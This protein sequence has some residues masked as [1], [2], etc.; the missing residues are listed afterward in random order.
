[1]ADLRC[2]RRVIHTYGLT[3]CRHCGASGDMECP[4]EGLD[5]SL[6]NIKPAAV[7]VLGTPSDNE[8]CSFCQ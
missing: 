7:C 3:E 6:L 8:E 1:M 5:S 4:Y 2:D